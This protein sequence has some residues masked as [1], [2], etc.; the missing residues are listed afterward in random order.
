MAD[1]SRPYDCLGI[2]Y[3]CFNI[4]F[5][6]ISM[7]KA[8]KFQLYLLA[9]SCPALHP[10]SV[11]SGNERLLVVFAFVLLLVPLFLIVPILSYH[12]FILLLLYKCTHF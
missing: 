2:P 4:C 11:D 9:T 5:S 1:L 6:F 3:S 7:T 12:L 10:S 8:T